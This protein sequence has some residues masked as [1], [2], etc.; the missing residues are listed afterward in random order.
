MAVSPELEAEIHRLHHA[1]GWPG[2]TVARQLG[3]HD[4]V[5]RR[6]LGLAA[7]P[8]RPRRA[9][10]V[11]DYVPFIEETLTQWPTLRSTRI[12][13]MVRD[14]GFPGAARTVRRHV[15]R[16]R[17]RKPREAFLRTSPLIGEQSQIDWAFIGNVDVDGTRRALW[18]FVIILSWSRAIWAES[19][20]AMDASAVARSLVRASTAFGGVTR[21]WLFDNPK[22]IVIERV[23]EDI[24][25]FHPLLLST[26]TALR[27]QPRLCT[28]RRANEKGKV[29]RAIR[30]MR[31]RALS[32]WTPTTIDDAN[33]RLRCFCD[34]VALDRPH[35]T[36]INKTVRQC[37]IE[38]QERLLALP[39]HLPPTDE[40]R[41]AVVDKT[42]F[43]RFDANDYSVPHDL[44]GKTVTVI[45]SDSVV[46]VV[47]VGVEVARHHRSYSRKRVVED[48]Q[49]RSNLIARKQAAKNVKRRE[50]LQ[51]RF[52]AFVKLIERWLEEARNVGSCVARCHIIH[53]LYGDEIFAEAVDDFGA[54]G[55]IDPG[56]LESLC[57]QLRQQRSP[58]PTP[59][60]PPSH[61]NDRDVTPHELESYDEP[62]NRHR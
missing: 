27:V 24:V 62:T 41:S 14:R 58:R 44:V 20:F 59:A 55:L 52:P 2:G 28:P 18:M 26:T 42:A 12:F 60:S 56:A 15:A 51:E 5:V 21:Q 50:Q 3:I 38:E 33:Q 48:P 8:M 32:G 22:T 61:P 13:D 49:H 30:F 47:D 23:T 25:R 7:P 37:L 1:E 19:C 11:D 53:D 45:A 43:V 31:D 35:P 39:E 34:G 4:D 40:F 46:R 54:R 16:L 36:I 9:S 17:P 29:E 10:I 6:V 57:E